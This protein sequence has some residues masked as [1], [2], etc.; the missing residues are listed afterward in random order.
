M[1]DTRREVAYGFGE[2]DELTLAYAITIHKSQG[3]EYPAVVIPLPTQ[4][5]TMLQ[6]NLL[7][8]GG[9]PRQ[10]PGGAGRA[11][12]GASRSPCVASRPGAAGR[13]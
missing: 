11:A 9:D 13:S 4:H 2:L 3:A 1:V 8:T 10:A 5:Y 7:Y 12:E 6:R